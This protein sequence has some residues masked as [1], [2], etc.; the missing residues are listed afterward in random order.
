MSLCLSSHVLC[1]SFHYSQ[2][3]N[4]SD[5]IR[6]LGSSVGKTLKPNSCTWEKETSPTVNPLQ[7]ELWWSRFVQCRPVYELVTV[8][9][10]LLVAC[11][12]TWSLCGSAISDEQT[13][14][15]LPNSSL[16][17]YISNPPSLFVFK[18]LLALI[19]RS[20]AMFT[21]VSS[22]ILGMQARR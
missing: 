21:D 12:W 3:C 15:G 14:K 18:L 7:S 16:N 17:T 6:V 1:S 10:S 20:P 5:T 8:Q 19:P 9:L 11:K 4:C 2:A 13:G 22:L